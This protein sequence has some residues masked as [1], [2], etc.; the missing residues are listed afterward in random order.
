MVHLPSRAG[1]PVGTACAKE[2]LSDWSGEPEGFLAV[3]PA[4]WLCKALPSQ[5]NGLIWRAVWIFWAFWAGRKWHC[6][7]YRA[8]FD[9]ASLYSF[10]PPK[11]WIGL[12]MFSSQPFNPP[13]QFQSSAFHGLRKRV[14][15]SC[16]WE[17]ISHKAHRIHPWN[18]VNWIREETILT[19]VS[20]CKRGGVH[21]S[22]RCHW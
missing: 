8:V 4:H 1:A 15:A 19:E 14:C 22:H 12:R 13:V 3:I 5:Q 9:E 10:L 2:A 20:H 7:P 21:K 16:S 6:L 17:H 11:C 18:C